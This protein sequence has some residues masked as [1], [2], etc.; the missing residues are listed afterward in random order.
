MGNILHCRPCVRSD[1]NVTYGIQTFG[2]ICKGFE[3]ALSADNARSMGDK[4]LEIFLKVF[5]EL[6]HFQ[7]AIDKHC[8]VYYTKPVKTERPGKMRKHLTGPDRNAKVV[9]SRLAQL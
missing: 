2:N 1:T 6:P 9:T 5:R 7:P 8:N 3:R 4:P